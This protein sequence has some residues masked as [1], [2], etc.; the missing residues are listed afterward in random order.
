LADSAP[1]RGLGARIAALG[2]NR[3]PRP[4][5]SSSLSRMEPWIPL[6][7]AALGFVARGHY[8][9][10]GERGRL[11]EQ[12]E[13][14]LAIYEKLPDSQARES[15]REH[16]ELQVRYL[17]AF[18]TPRTVQE[19]LGRSWGL[20]WV[21]VGVVVL[22]GIGLS[23]GWPLTWVAWASVAGALIAAGGFATWTRARASQNQRRWERL[24]AAEEGR[25]ESPAPSPDDPGGPGV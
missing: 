17:L 19:R 6:I 25:R 1:N 11:P 10:V 15:L 20:V 18:E 4:R 12:L 9:R 3:S 8:L 14:H 22:P 24:A 21:L 16:I 7:T 23:E 2:G 5:V 13:R